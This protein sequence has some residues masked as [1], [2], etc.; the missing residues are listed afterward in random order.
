M[1]DSHVD[2]TGKLESSGLDLLPSLL[3]SDI[4]PD[5]G[6]LDAVTLADE[7]VRVRLSLLESL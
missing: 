6:R 1:L 7:V 2:T 3:A 4:S 5:E